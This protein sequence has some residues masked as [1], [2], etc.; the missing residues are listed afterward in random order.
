MRA[1]V[2]EAASA[3]TIIESLRLELQ[4]HPRESDTSRKG[5]VSPH[6]KEAISIIEATERR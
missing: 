5:A 4:A 6:L 3:A 1:Q 2:N